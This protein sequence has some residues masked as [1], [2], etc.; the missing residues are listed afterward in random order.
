MSSLEQT[1]APG[2]RVLYRTGLHWILYTAAFGPAGVV[3]GGAIASS[4]IP[5][6]PVRSTM[7]VMATVALAAGLFQLLAIW[8]RIRATT[9]I[10]TNRRV[11]YASGVLSRRSIEMNRDKVESVVIDQSLTGRLLDFGTVVI[12]G[13]GAGLEP[14]ANV[15]APMEFRRQV[16]FE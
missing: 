11:I 7:L 8:A 6:G 9:I 16:G 13:V 4:L 1:L 14:V 12:R 15:V 2:E 5:D 3:V 10:V